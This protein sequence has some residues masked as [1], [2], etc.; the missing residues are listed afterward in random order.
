MN[1]GAWYFSLV[2][3]SE[4]LRYLLMSLIFRTGLLPSVNH[5]WK[6]PHSMPRDMIYYA[7]RWLSIKTSWQSRLSIMAGQSDKML[8]Y[9]WERSEVTINLWEFCAS[10][11]MWYTLLPKID[12]HW[13]RHIVTTCHPFRILF[14][15]RS[16][17]FQP[18]KTTSTS[19]QKFIRK[20]PFHSRASHLA[21]DWASKERIIV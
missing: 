18:F 3:P 4:L 6:C 21:C 7:P 8:G 9:L 13:S 19:H 1:I 2:I 20:L 12:L 10:L 11:W 17:R 5:L 14:Q 15:W 16:G